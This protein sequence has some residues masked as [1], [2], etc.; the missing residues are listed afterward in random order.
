MEM[1]SLVSQDAS[2]PSANMTASLCFYL[3]LLLLI[4]PEWLR[5]KQQPVTHVLTHAIHNSELG[6]KVLRGFL[7]GR[8]RTRS[9]GNWFHIQNP[10]LWG[11]FH[12]RERHRGM[13]PLTRRGKITRNT[14]HSIERASQELNPSDLA[15]PA[16]YE[17][18][19]RPPDIL[20]KNKVA[21][22]NQ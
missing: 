17:T 1:S 15:M 14:D 13:R 18:N 22:L 4:W 19:H 10:T 6:R 12:V 11:C 7:P 9:S 16:A 8:Q 3:V 2:P 5:G 21:I 20:S